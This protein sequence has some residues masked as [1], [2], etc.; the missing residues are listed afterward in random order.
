MNMWKI[1]GGAALGV[2][3]VA[4]LPVAGPIGA[5]TAIGAAVAGTAGAAAGGVAEYYD[6]DEE[7]AR[8]EGELEGEERAKRKAEEAK[9]KA[10]KEAKRKAEEAK[11]SKEIGRAYYA[12]GLACANCDGIDSKEIENIGDLLN[13]FGL[14]QDDEDMETLTYEIA[15]EVN[16]AREN[17]D[18][19]RVIKDAVSKSS[20]LAFNMFK[21]ILNKHINPLFWAEQIEHLDKCIDKIIKADGTTSEKEEDFLDEWKNYKKHFFA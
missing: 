9:R 5:V 4:A 10:R 17:S 19:S 16:K 11:R 14:K 13:E 18:D 1:L 15:H 8:E 20:L 21:K 2:V 12:I 3:A 6:N 7:K